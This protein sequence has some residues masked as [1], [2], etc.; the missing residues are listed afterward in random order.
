MLLSARSVSRRRRR[1]RRPPDTQRQ[2]IR[3][4][5]SIVST[6]AGR[7]YGRICEQVPPEQNVNPNTSCT[8]NWTAPVAAVSPT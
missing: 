4:T 8:W 7:V 6:R 1:S 2:F 3:G 5:N